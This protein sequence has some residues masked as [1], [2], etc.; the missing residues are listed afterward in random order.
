[1]P[2]C[3]Y[4]ARPLRAGGVRCRACRRWVFGWQHLLVLALLGVAA[5]YGLLELLHLLSAK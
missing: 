3:P 2:K 4:C 1:M 5:V